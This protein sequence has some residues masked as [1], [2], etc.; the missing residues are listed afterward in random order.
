[1]D[2]GDEPLPLIWS[3]EHGCFGYYFNPAAVWITVPLESLTMFG[4]DISV[5]L[6]RL[7]AKME[8]GAGPN[9][10]SGA[11]RGLGNW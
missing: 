2:H 1:M 10:L 9:L 4:V 11:E 3:G 6:A 7:M 5:L 8:I